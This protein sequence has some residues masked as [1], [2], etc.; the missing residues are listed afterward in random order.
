MFDGPHSW[1]EDGR[2]FFR[3]SISGLLVRL[4]LVTTVLFASTLT[5]RKCAWIQ[6]GRRDATVAQAQSARDAARQLDFGVA[7]EKASV[8]LLLLSDAASSAAEEHAGRAVV[9]AAL[10]DLTTL[11]ATD[12]ELAIKMS[13]IR[14]A[15]GH[16]ERRLEQIRSMVQQS[17]AAEARAAVLALRGESTLPWPTISTKI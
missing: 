13:G 1:V 6:H 12:P 11:S 16:L 3:Q 4:A 14:A 7:A 2:R 17:R 9:A 8:R 5:W 15:I 10:A